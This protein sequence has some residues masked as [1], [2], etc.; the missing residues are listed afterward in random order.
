MGL[1]L[2]HSDLE[3]LVNVACDAK[4]WIAAHVLKR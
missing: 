4:A 1:R 2:S 3:A